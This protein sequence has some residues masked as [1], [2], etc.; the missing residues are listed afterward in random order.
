[1]GG[2]RILGAALL[3]FVVAST[4]ARAEEPPPASGTAA[5]VVEQAP[6]SEHPAPRLKAAYRWFQ[7]PNLDGSRLAFNAGS[8]D[9]YAL[10]RRWFRLGFEAEGGGASGFVQNLSL[11]PGAGTLVSAPMSAWYAA[12]GLTAGLQYP[13]RVTPF[14]EGRFLAGL[15]GGDLA[16]QRAVSYAWLGGLDAGVELYLAGRFYLTASVGWVRPF[17]RGVDRQ[18]MQA[19]PT[20]DP[21]FVT[22]STDS[23]TFKIGLGL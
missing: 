16:G 5:S 14:I 8:V 23:F 11:G 2:T 9:V 22:L 21:Q 15:V 13:W 10:S 19:H 12:G 18:Y 3:A 1:M 6:P 20:A 17:Y 4:G 7:M